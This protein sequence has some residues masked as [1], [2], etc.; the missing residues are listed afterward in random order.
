MTMRI[1]HWIGGQRQ[2]GTS[3]LTAPVFDA[4]T[5]LRTG[6]KIARGPENGTWAG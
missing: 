6:E 2:P 5:G 1:P 4:A 3:G